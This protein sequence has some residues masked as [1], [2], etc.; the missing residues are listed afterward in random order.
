MGKFVKLKFTDPK[1][2]D[3]L[4]SRG[5]MRAQDGGI[6]AVHVPQHTAPSMSGVRNGVPF[7]E[8]GAFVPEH[9]EVC[10]PNRQRLMAIIENTVAGNEQ[11]VPVT[12]DRSSSCLTSVTLVDDLRDLP[13]GYICNTQWAESLHNS[14]SHGQLINLGAEFHAAAHPNGLLVSALV[15]A[16]AKS[17]QLK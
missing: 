6:V 12:F 4:F 10:K 16:A 15:D 13:P 2:A 11:L 7:T 14:G 9:V 8:G 1:I 3:D 17:G 5:A